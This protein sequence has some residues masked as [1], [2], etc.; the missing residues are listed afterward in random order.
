[1]FLKKGMQNQ[2]VQRIQGRLD[3][4]NYDV[5]PVDGFFGSRTERAVM[6]F[7]T[8]QGLSIDGIV[9]NETWG[10]LFNESLPLVIETLDGTPAYSQCFDIFGDFRI[11]GWQE[12]N[13]VRCDLSAYEGELK[14]LYFGWMTSDDRAFAHNTWFGFVCHR[15]AA[16]K[17]QA[18]F[19]KVVES[20][21][22]GSLRTFDGC[23]NPR[24]MRGSDRWS[25]HSWGIAIDIDAPWNRFGQASFEMS[26]DLAQCFEEE[27]FI[28]GGR[29]QRRPDAMHFQYCTVR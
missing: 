21:L 5:G 17:F 10:A 24:H 8:D 13:L 12:Q 9:G 11:A 19:G 20:N 18:A 3:T 14:H 23:F 15:L 6:A 2:N 1:M 16:P 29:W 22:H 7:Q 4:L 26:E 27:G 28:W 25:T